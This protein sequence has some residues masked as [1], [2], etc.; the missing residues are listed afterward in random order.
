MYFDNK[1]DK[2]RKPKQTTN[3]YPQHLRG[4]PQ[5]R[6]GGHRTQRQRG[7]PGWSRGAAGPVK[8]YTKEECEVVELDMK[9]RGLI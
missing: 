3:S 8:H 1:S 9:R 7:F 5:N 2:K 6:W 4:L